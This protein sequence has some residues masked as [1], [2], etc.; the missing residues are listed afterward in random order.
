MKKTYCFFASTNFCTSFLSPPLLKPWQWAAGAPIVNTSY[1]WS[2]NIWLQSLEG[3]KQHTKHKSLY[4][5]KT[6]LILH[7]H[8][9]HVQVGRHKLQLFVCFQVTG[10]ERWTWRVEFKANNGLLMVCYWSLAQYFIDLPTFKIHEDTNPC[11]CWGQTV[12]PGIFEL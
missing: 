11:S 9:L 2:V 3:W 4:L 8:P 6:Q 7:P 1:V 5:T 12:F 10:F